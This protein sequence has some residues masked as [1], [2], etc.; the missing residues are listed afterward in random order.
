[1]S[2]YVPRVRPVVDQPDDHEQQPGY[3]PVREELQRGAVQPSAVQLRRSRAHRRKAKHDEP[4][5]TDAAVCDEAFQVGLTHDDERAVQH[6]HH[7]EQRQQRSRRSQFVGE[8]PGVDAQ[9]AVPPHL[10]QH[11]REHHAHRCRRVRM[12]VRQPCVQ[13]NDGQFYRERPRGSPLNTSDDGT[14]RFVRS[15]WMSAVMS[16]VR[17]PAGK[18]K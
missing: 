9:Q 5:V 16:N 8:H 17:S 4:N 15:L 11:P 7:C 3:R 18:E 13:G 14:M 6:V 12:R 2:R 10:Q 1:M